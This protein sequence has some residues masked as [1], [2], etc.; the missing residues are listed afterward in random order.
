MTI[1]YSI[2]VFSHIAGRSYKMQIGLFYYKRNRHVPY[3]IVSVKAA[4]ARTIK[5][6]E[7]KSRKGMTVRLYVL[8]Y[9]PPVTSAVRLLKIP[10]S[11]TTQDP[12][13]EPRRIP[14]IRQRLGETLFHP[15]TQPRPARWRR[16]LGF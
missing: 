14:Q 12:S 4:G 5:E 10:P 8:V 9:A 7:R 3:Y 15:P 16:Q 1:L 6:E 2:F 13:T 11:S